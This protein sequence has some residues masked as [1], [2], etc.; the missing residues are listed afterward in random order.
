ML[1]THTAKTLMY[2]G[3]GVMIVGNLTASK[4]PD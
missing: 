1:W 3:I 2:V 4:D